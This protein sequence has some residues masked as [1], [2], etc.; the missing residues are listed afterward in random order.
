MPYDGVTIGSLNINCWKKFNNHVCCDLH[1]IAVVVVTNTKTSPGHMYTIFVFLHN[2]TCWRPRLYSP[3]L[4][5]ITKAR[6]NENN[7]SN[8]RVGVRQAHITYI[9]RQYAAPGPNVV[10]CCKNILFARTQHVPQWV[11]RHDSIIVRG[12]VFL[13]T[14]H[15]IKIAYYCCCYI[16]R[17]SRIT[18]HSR[19]T[20]DERRA[21]RVSMGD[22]DGTNEINFRDTSGLDTGNRR[23]SFRLCVPDPWTRL[24]NCA[25]SGGRLYR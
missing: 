5:T 16:A 9:Y 22:D 7:K 10:V 23:D 1:S 15:T 13:H 12:R 4:Y 18:L 25:V 24:H 17:P 6:D 3:K 20:T 19:W 21:D 14:R 8:D 11:P 2:A